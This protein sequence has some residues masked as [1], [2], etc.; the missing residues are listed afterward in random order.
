[1]KKVL[2]IVLCATLWSCAPITSRDTETTNNAS[3]YQQAKKM[4]QVQENTS[5]KTSTRTATAAPEN[6]N[7]LLAS[8]PEKIIASDAAAITTL[9]PVVERQTPTR[10]NTFS[11][12]RD[13]SIEQ[14]PLFT[15]TR[16]G[17][18]FL[19]MPP[20]A[21]AFVQAVPAQTCPVRSIGAHT[22]K[23]ADAA[24]VALNNCENALTQM[25]IAS[26]CDCQL[27]ATNNI[28]LDELETFTY[29]T[30]V[31]AVFVEPNT[32]NTQSYIMEEV[33]QDSLDRVFVFYRLNNKVGTATLFADGTLTAT[34]D[35]P[36]T[37]KWYAE[38]YQ[39]GHLVVRMFL[40]TAKNERLIALI[41]YEPDEFKNRLYEINQWIADE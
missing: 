36:Y 40:K 8:E 19:E 16:E 11:D 18:E 29:A 15:Q 34:L 25:S 21:R 1:M 38:G 41:G 9:L 33:T 28:L 2:Y 35:Q 31:S 12:T 39:R 14:L 30:G 24:V 37:G 10:L 3:P 23:P 20:L 4:I 27:I 32:Q 7:F 13:I 26:R 17:I 6:Q 5:A 22:A